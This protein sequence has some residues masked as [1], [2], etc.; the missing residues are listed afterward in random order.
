MAGVAAATA[1]ILLAGCGG[2]AASDS[3]KTRPLKTVSVAMGFTQNV[4]FAP[5]YAAQKL[6]YYRAAGLRTQ[7]NYTSEPNALSLLSQGK[8]DFVDSGGDE[9]LAAGAGGLHVRY[10]L[11]QYSRFPSAL[12]FLRS[13]HIRTVRDLA[14]KTI[15][16]PAM[17][18]ASYYGL[19]ALLRSNH[20]KASSV[21]LESINYTQVTS[22]ADGKV[23]AAMG[24]APNEPVELRSQGKAVGEF[25]IYRWDNLAGAGIAASNREISHNPHLVRAFVQATLKG[26]RFTLQ[27]PNQAFAISK[28][29]IP[30]LQNPSLQRQVL[31]RAIDFWKPA[32][33]P[34]GH[35][36]PK[37]WNL[38]AQV[39]HV[40]RQIR[41]P[42]QAS[43]FYTNRFVP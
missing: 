22:V 1:L 2:Q 27:H 37:V 5:F 26:L 15:G 38:T 8:I 25:D 41:R 4:Q 3:H 29:A 36:D 39:L 19:L 7:F 43:N 40:F 6:G 20:V 31:M 28:K 18:G 33:V 16:V 35:M 21:H 9:V 42:V 13:S 30:G 17:Y 24:Y 10:V 11:T 12:F 34:L 23:A 32:G 14:G